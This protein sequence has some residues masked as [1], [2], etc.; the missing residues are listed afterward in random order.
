[1]FFLKHYYILVAVSLMSTYSSIDCM[2]PGA[3]DQESPQVVGIDPLFAQPAVAAVYKALKGRLAAALASKR[4]GMSFE[5][6]Q[7]ILDDVYRINRLLTLSNVNKKKCKTDYI[8]TFENIARENLEHTWNISPYILHFARLQL[9][10]CREFFHEN[11]DDVLK[12]LDQKTK[13]NLQMLRK[14]VE[15]AG[16]MPLKGSIHHEIFMDRNNLASGTARYMRKTMAT[17]S[18]AITR[19]SDFFDHQFE[20][21]IEMCDKFK[22]LTEFLAGQFNAFNEIDVQRMSDT[23][24]NWMKTVRICDNILYFSPDRQSFSTAFNIEVVAR[25]N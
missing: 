6:H 8:E 22:S 12:E 1:M 17:S 14:D 21:L 4:N 23:D 2:F 25:R 18:R 10:L 16:I 7:V 13:D 11:L 24:I 20:D 5:Q 15:A 19:I 3:L 9:S